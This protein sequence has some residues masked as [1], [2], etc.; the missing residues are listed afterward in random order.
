M[1]TAD[2]LKTD[3]ALIRQRTVSVL[4]ELSTTNTQFGLATFPKEL[5]EYRKRFAE[6]TYN[7]LVVGEA[8]GGKSSFVNA[9]IGRDLLPTDVDIATNQ[10]FRV[11]QAEKDSFALR[12]DNGSTLPISTAE[13]LEYGSQAVRDR[14]EPSRVNLDHLNWIEVNVP[15]DFLPTGI[16]LLDTPGLGS[17]YAVH[18]Q[19]TQRFVPLADAV[20]FVLDS[21][22]P[23]GEFELQFLE[24]ILEVTRHVF[25][26]QTKIDL[27]DK[28]HWQQIQQRHQTILA[29]RFG[30]H[31][32]DTHVWPI[33]NRNLLKATEMKEQ[34][35]NRAGFL[36]LSRQPELSDALELFLFKV[37][38]VNRCH[39]ALLLADHYYMTSRKMLASQL[40]ALDGKS[41]QEL[42]NQQQQVAQLL[43]QFEADWG[44]RGK[45]KWELT[46]GGQKIAATTTQSMVSLIGSKGEL[47]TSQLEKI[48]AV[49]SIDEVNKLSQIIS[50]EIV[51]VTAT[52]WRQLCE[53]A[54]LQDST[55]PGSLIQATDALEFAPEDPRLPAHIGTPVTVKDDL[56][57]KFSIVPESFA[58]A[59]TAAGTTLLIASFFVPPI[60][61][62]VIVIG[63]A[64]AGILAV[65]RSWKISKAEQLAQARNKLEEYLSTVMH[66]VR[67][68][69][70]EPDMA[71]KGMSLVNYH[72]D[73]LVN[74]INDQIEAIVEKKSEDTRKE[75]ARLE[76]QIKMDK[77]QRA[78]RK[79]ELQQQLAEWDQLGRS[80]RA[81]NSQLTDLEQ[82]LA[83]SSTIASV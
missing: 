11:T 16:S 39:D 54:R 35:G 27:Y 31:L 53:Q 13:L 61:A 1:S 71:Y 34:G 12:F 79:E 80:L 66:E 69:F 17:L 55:L 40:A 37:A 73:S 10:V 67:K 49:Q 20:I 36:K 4:E 58:K 22:G 60:T 2:T 65:A 59:G 74:M 32:V 5:E 68:R 24:N 62:G 3:A 76:E 64:I 41:T 19:I 82:R 77:E 63:A 33:S 70:L 9:L 8:K 6:N 56:I 14:R 30:D 57:N 48:R 29:E 72:F 83:V 45:K 46:S 28:G 47:E 42:V 18:A 43:Q 78:A 25:F 75:S 81:T 15:I 52:R 21:S 38:G 44:P 50:E 51:T 26:I 7:V 23:M